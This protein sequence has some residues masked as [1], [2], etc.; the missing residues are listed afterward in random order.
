M[1]GAT[2]I[3]STINNLHKQLIHRIGSNETLPHCTVLVI[4]L[5]R[6]LPQTGSVNQIGIIENRKSLRHA[7][8]TLHQLSI[9]SKNIASMDLKFFVQYYQCM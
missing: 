5:N 1:D 3:R 8:L 7:K 4:T 6:F 2:N 9:I